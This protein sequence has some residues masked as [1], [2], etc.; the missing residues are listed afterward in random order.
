MYVINRS[1]VLKY[2]NITLDILRQQN[3]L[4][5]KS[6][7][8]LDIE[9]HL[10]MDQITKFKTLIAFMRYMCI[11]SSAT[12]KFSTYFTLNKVCINI[13]YI[14]INIYLK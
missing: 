7:L 8:S 14:Y 1:E 11:H 3:L 12:Y 10:L 2:L 9:I 5:I 4:S 13:T 6:T